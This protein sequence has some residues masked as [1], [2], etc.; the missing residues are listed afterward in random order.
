MSEEWRDI[1]SPLDRAKRLSRELV[2]VDTLVG[3]TERLSFDSDMT[4]ADSEPPHA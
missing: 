3:I 4:E 2:S 1:E